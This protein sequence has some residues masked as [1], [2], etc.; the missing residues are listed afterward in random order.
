MHVFHENTFVADD[1]YM[2]RAFF[3]PV[4][5]A[6]RRT[7]IHRRCR[8]AV[9]RVKKYLFIPELKIMSH[10]YDFQTADGHRRAVGTRERLDDLLALRTA[11]RA[12]GKTSV[13]SGVG[14]V[15]PRTVRGLPG[16]PGCDRHVAPGPHPP[17][18]YP[19]T[20]CTSM[21]TCAFARGIPIRMARSSPPTPRRSSRRGR[22]STRLR[23]TKAG[24]IHGVCRG[25]E[26]SFTP[27]YYKQELLWNLKRHA[28]DRHR[29]GW[30]ASR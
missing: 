15:L 16:T 26:F 25:S 3:M 22:R 19:E 9:P 21:I 27:E 4:L 13:A 23:S 7:P 17:D 14:R 28:R 12:A 18:S 10:V 6:D 29:A 2:K 30:Q 11:R 24:N 5:P 8:A 20:S 1:L